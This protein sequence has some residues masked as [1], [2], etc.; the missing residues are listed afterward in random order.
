LSTESISPWSYYAERPFGSK[1]FQRISGVNMDSSLYLFS[2]V[3]LF[4]IFDAEVEQYSIAIEIDDDEQLRKLDTSIVY[5]GKDFSIRSCS[6]S[7]VL[8][9]WNCRIIYFD[10]RAYRQSRL[11]IEASRNSKIGLR[12]PWVYLDDGVL[13]EDLVSKINE[14]LPG[15]GPDD[16]SFNVEKGALWGY[17]LGCSRSI[18]EK[19]AILVS[20]SN[21]MRNIASNAISNSGECGRAFYEELKQ[22]D[23]DYREIADKEANDQWKAFCSPEESGI[24][25]RFQVLKEALNKFLSG[26]RLS[27]APEVP[28]SRDS[29]DAWVLYRD[30]LNSYTDAF[31]NKERWAS[32]TIPW[33]D[34]S[35]HDGHLSLCNYELI[36][37]LLRKIS[38]GEL[39]KE[40]I[41][42]N[43][44]SSMKMVLSDVSTILQKRFGQEAWNQHPEDR[45]YINQLYKNITDFE[46]FNFNSS[47]NEELKAIAAFL[48]KGEDYDALVR[49]LEDN[50]SADY[51]LVLCLWGALEGYAAIHKNLLTAVLT[52]DNVSKVNIILG[53]QNTSMPFPIDVYVP[54][55]FGIRESRT[56][57]RGEQA[58]VES[59]VNKGELA[60][61]GE[62]GAQKVNHEATTPVD[63]FEVFFSAFVEK[64]KAA[65]NDKSIYLR[66]FSQYSGLTIDFYNAV[67]SE[68]S[69]NKGKGAQRNVLQYIEKLVKPVDTNI[70]SKSTPITSYDSPTVFDDSIP[71]TGVF[72][73]DLEFLSNNSEFKMLASSAHKN[74]LKDLTW[75]IEVHDPENTEGYYKG[76]PTDNKTVII[77]FINLKRQRYFSTKDFLFRVYGING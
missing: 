35:F 48:L 31:V 20:L 59:G 54:K 69:L 57:R 61:S 60:P 26:R 34:I 2:K 11:A 56:R 42:V 16:L 29:K 55:S 21:R 33:N 24:L 65:K 73:N 66:L 30:S 36:N 38:R 63:D 49:Y 3:P 6:K 25:E 41:R 1:F 10:E 7:I 58:R 47:Q 53:V 28:N 23:K 18:P 15:E 9:P 71:S 76:K 68:K 13:L 37:C 46:P 74:W 32:A 52:A 64:C 62:G 17:V 19:A 67:S 14:D 8:T 72:L 40:Q 77:Q 27:Q 51:R 4:T 5:D 44:E 75:F 70:K 22:L 39:N 45:L 12:Y 43:R 50:S